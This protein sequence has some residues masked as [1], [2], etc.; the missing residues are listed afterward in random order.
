M[1]LETVPETAQEEELE[2]S[3]ATLYFF[4]HLFVLVIFKSYFAERQFGLL[5]MFGSLKIPVTIDI[6]FSFSK[7]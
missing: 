5:I 3:E 1:T 4:N 7:F 6:S 2:A